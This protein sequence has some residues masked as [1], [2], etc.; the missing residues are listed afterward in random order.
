MS[1]KEIILIYDKECPACHNYCQLVQIR[2]TVGEL[3][4]ID[5]RENSPVM[6]EITAQGLDID[7]VWC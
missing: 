5:A 7:Q 3:K 1:S 2:R 6:D 4:I